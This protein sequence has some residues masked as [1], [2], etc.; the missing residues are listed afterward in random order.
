MKIKNKRKFK[1][2]IILLLIVIMICFCFSGSVQAKDAD[3]G[4]I[5]LSPIG[6]LVV[7]IGDG[8]MNIIHSAIYH[9]NSTTITVDMMSSVLSKV[10]TVAVGIFAAVI[11]A[12]AVVISA[13]AAVAAFAAIGVTL[14]AVSVGTVLVISA[15][16]G[17]AAAALFNSNIL[18][19]TL[20]LPVYQISPEQIFSNQVLLFD[21][22]FFNPKPDTTAKDV[23]GNEIVDEAGNPVELQSTAKQLRGVISNWYVVLRNI[24]VVALLSILVYIGI[25]IL[26]SSTSNDKSKYKQML[27]DWVVAIC[28]LFVMQYIMSFSNLLVG[29]ITDVLTGIKTDKGYFAILE[30]KDGK[31]EKELKEREYDVDSMKDNGTDPSDGSS[32]DFIKWPTNLMGIA[33]LNAQMAKKENTSYIGYSIVFFVLVIYTISFCF[34]YIRRVLYM[35]FL[36]IIAPFVA[37]TYPIDKINDGKAQAFD[38]WFKEY[39]FNLLIQPMHLILYTILVSSAFE[40]ASENIIYSLVALG[41]MM[42]A[43]KL[44]RR[45]FGFEK[46]HTPGLL[47]GPAGAAMMM[48][49]MNQLLKKG[50]SGGKVSSKNG[51]TAGNSEEKAPRVNKKLNTDFD[52]EGALFGNGGLPEGNNTLPNGENQIGELNEGLGFG[53]D[54][55]LDT[56]YNA[57]ELNGNN[58]YLGIQG[59]GGF[60]NQ[61][62]DATNYL[63]TNVG[64]GQQ[65]PNNVGKIDE[66]I[67]FNDN[68]PNLGEENRLGIGQQQDNR[69]RMQEPANKEQ[70]KSG[71]RRKISGIANNG[72]RMARAGARAVLPTAKYYAR[73]VGNELK[74]RAA[75]SVKTAP[76]RLARTT[77]SAAGA[78]TVGA[79]GLAFGVASGDPTKAF[80]Y[81]AAAGAA[82][83]KLGSG[84]FDNADS[85]TPE[86]ADEIV[87]RSSFETDEEYNRFKQNNYNKE[88]F[89]AKKQYE[90]ERR[91]GDKT[92]NEMIKNDVPKLLDNGINDM[93][94]IKSI[95]DMKQDG[96]LQNMDEVT[97]MVNNGVNDI[98][99]METIL[100]LRQEGKIRDLKHGI[101]VKK[102]ASRIG[103][104]TTNMNSDDRAKWEKTFTND[105]KNSEKLQGRDDYEDLGRQTFEWVNDF[106]SK[107]QQ[108]STARDL[109]VKRVK[110]ETTNNESGVQTRTS[111]NNRDN[112]TTRTR[113]TKENTR[114]T[115]RTRNKKKY[116]K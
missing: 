27:G 18:P 82:G 12:A 45:F 103:K 49:G 78:A 85:L 17:I 6:D 39:I 74:R 62:D 24:A 89:D 36:T 37:M 104:D 110:N 113:R 105:Y 99:D 111:I 58:D 61:L 20:E 47:A 43:E 13:G 35:A 100:E 38:S 29:K 88:F 75:N 57:N 106:N 5:L 96:K 90:L 73:G 69:L 87:L 116:R 101:A 8:I 26:I 109:G 107:K 71:I 3:K 10:L 41:F 98:N 15:G 7:F 54:G 32:H 48:S 19:D 23:N 42:P 67:R 84:V 22:D 72:A 97:T 1:R 94:K 66:G 9:Q 114:N 68:I 51:G 92:A 4:G 63:G 79:F 34:T 115:T 112:N 60:S 70:P 52:T 77:A 83:A 33:R 2:L 16:A 65:L 76:R 102:Q 44:L 93:D 31:I 28:L 14:S 80:Q 53:D 30:D 21:V 11:A 86:G 50:P 25:R 91:Y 55:S 95:L 46:A 56:P 81:T 59:A 64:Q 40:L 108:I